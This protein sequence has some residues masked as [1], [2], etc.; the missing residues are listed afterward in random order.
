MGGM[1]RGFVGDSPLAEEVKFAPIFLIV[2]VNFI[3]STNF[4]ANMSWSFALLMLS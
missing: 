1:Y 3:F 2:M 4:E